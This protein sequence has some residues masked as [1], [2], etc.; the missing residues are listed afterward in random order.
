MEGINSH[1]VMTTTGPLL[2]SDIERELLLELRRLV[3]RVNNVRKEIQ[4][5]TVDLE[6]LRARLNA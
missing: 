6:R 1:N 5:K 2:R 4:A 3:E